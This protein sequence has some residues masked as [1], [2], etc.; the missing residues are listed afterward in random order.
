[1]VSRWQPLAV[2][3]SLI[4]IRI[5]LDPVAATDFTLGSY[6]VPARRLSNGFPLLCDS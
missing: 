4:F 2:A 5:A 3:A 6:T 1:M